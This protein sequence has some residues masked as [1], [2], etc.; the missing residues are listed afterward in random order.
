MA[1][2]SVKEP[3]PVAELSKEELTVLLAQKDEE[4]LK[5]N[6]QVVKSEHKAVALSEKIAL[7]QT[8]PTIAEKQAELDYS[9][10]MAKQFSDSR[11]F[12]KDSTPEQ[13]YVLMKAGAEMGL[14][15]VESLQSLYIVNGQIDF[16]GD[17]MIAQLTKHGYKVEY[18]DEISEKNKERVTAVVTSR[19]GKFK[20]METATSQDQIILQ[21]KAAKFALKNKLR[22]HAI[23]MIAS[24]HL[25][26]LFG[27]VGDQ[28]TK[29]F[30][31]WKEANEV[32]EYRP[33]QKAIPTRADQNTE[34]LSMDANDV[35]ESQVVEAKEEDI[36]D[37]AKSQ[38]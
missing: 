24:F 26:H 19:D 16:Y 31:E 25:P 37:F 34:N 14:K 4:I 6:Q 7:M 23:R 20:A 15:E 3:K 13:I 28:F 21:S 32:S 17:K 36:P 11:A 29:E 30:T 10:K 8:Y 27:S 22:F 1:K 18:I 9:L 12:S 5:L 35:Q 33:E 2:E 38:A